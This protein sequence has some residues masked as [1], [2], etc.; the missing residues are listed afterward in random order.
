MH[1][2]EDDNRSSVLTTGDEPEL[3]DDGIWRIPVP[4]PFALRSANIYLLADGPEDW[5]LVDAGLGLPSD[6]SAL[7]AGLEFA[8][9]RLEQITSLILTHCHPDHIGLSGPIHAASHAPVYMLS[10]EERTMYQVWGPQSEAASAEVSAMYLAH[11]MTPEELDSGHQSPNRTRAFLKLPPPQSIV[12]LE[13]GAELR[14]GDHTYRI[15]WTPGHSDRHMCLLRDDRLFIAGDHILPGITP[16]IGWYANGR[17]NPLDD[18]FWGLH[19]VR[20]LPARLVL[21]GHRLPFSSLAARV[22][23]LEAHHRKRGEAT[24]SLLSAAAPEGISASSIAHSLFGERLRTAD[25]L[26]FALAESLAHLEYLRSQ[27]RASRW[28][29]EGHILYAAIP[30]AQR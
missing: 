27:G 7:L 17:P 2:R 14:L 20:D 29:L 26:R 13:D 16:N 12:A 5:T 19:R 1:N 22:D 21:P 24:Y 6:E 28:N 15:I 11:G 30:T 4:L 23:E 10:G 18:Y 25:D 8:G 3:L 9:I